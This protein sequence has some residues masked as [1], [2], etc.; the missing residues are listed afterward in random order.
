MHDPR[1]LQ[2]ILTLTLMSWLHTTLVAA[3]CPTGTISGWSHNVRILTDP[4]IPVGNHIAHIFFTNSAHWGQECGYEINPLT[5]TPEPCD[6][7]SGLKGCINQAYNHV[8]L[9]HDA[10]LD[11]GVVVTIYGYSTTVTWNEVEE[12]YDY[13][14]A[15][16]TKLSD[17]S[18]TKNCHG[19]S[20]GFSSPGA[21]WLRS[22]IYGIDA[23]LADPICWDSSTPPL[24]TDHLV[25]YNPTADHSCK[26]LI[27]ECPEPC[28]TINQIV[29]I[30][31][32]HRDSGVY[33]KIGSCTSPLSLK[34][35]I[36]GNS[37]GGSYI[38]YTKEY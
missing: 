19:L 5:G 27:D 33:Q 30:Q 36:G 17:H 29:Y 9:N 21:G 13:E 31:E 24:H 3:D 6:C 32:K 28:T 15:G 22:G 11:T 35:T 26:V 4:N 37:L 34:T 14:Y 7:E 16:Y 8:H 10:V 18:L 23:L 25:A 38:F 20:F 1:L 2:L 12:F